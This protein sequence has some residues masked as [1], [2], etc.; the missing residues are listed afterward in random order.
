MLLFMVGVLVGH[1]PHAQEFCVPRLCKP[2]LGAKSPSDYSK[3][4]RLPPAAVLSDLAFTSKLTDLG[5]C[6]LPSDVLLLQADAA[7]RNVTIVTMDGLPQLLAHTPGTMKSTFCQ[8][9][10]TFTSIAT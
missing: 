10:R 5:G 2:P 9:G 8:A 3:Q 1:G 7:V 4:T 6:L